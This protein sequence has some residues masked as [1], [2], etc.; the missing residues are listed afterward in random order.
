TQ[1]SFPQQ[2]QGASSGQGLC[3]CCS[4]SPWPRLCS[5][6]PRSRYVQLLLSLVERIG[7]TKLAGTPRA[8]TLAHAA[9][10]LAQD[11]HQDTRLGA[12][13]AA[14]D[15]LGE[16]TVVGNLSLATKKEHCQLPVT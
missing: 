14:L 3:C 10:T 2:G 9:G 8:E 12:V 6:L 13:T 7:V 4:L 11:C 16:V 1:A 5:L 15:C